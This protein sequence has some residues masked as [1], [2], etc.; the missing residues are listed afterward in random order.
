MNMKKK[1]SKQSLDNDINKEFEQKLELEK[2][3]NQSFRYHEKQTENRNQETINNLMK[4]NK[5]NLSPTGGKK[6]FVKTQKEQM[7]PKRKGGWLSKDD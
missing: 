2:V 3:I 6:T 4:W 1:K 7:T 5:D